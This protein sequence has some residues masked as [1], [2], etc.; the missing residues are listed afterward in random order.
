MGLLDKFRAGRKD[1][2]SAEARGPVN[3]DE[4]QAQVDAGLTDPR[5]VRSSRADV[6]GDPRDSMPTAPTPSELAAIEMALDDVGTADLM[7]R[8]GEPADAGAAHGAQEAQ[9]GQTAT[10]DSRPRTRAGETIISQLPGMDGRADYGDSSLL[11]P[12]VQATPVAGV[13]T[14]APSARGR[15]AS[16]LRNRRSE[17]RR[18]RRA[19]ARALGAGGGGAASRAAPPSVHCHP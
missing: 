8:S 5:E 6:R 13:G 16:H 9:A 3:F 11:L 17:T 18:L 12:P 2:E 15:G 1:R 14:G 7:R 10:A 4:L 19:G